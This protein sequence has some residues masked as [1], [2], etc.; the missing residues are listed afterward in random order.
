PAS[1]GG[2][3]VLASG[4]DPEDPIPRTIRLIH[5]AKS[6]PPLSVETDAT[7]DTEGSSVW[8]AATS[9]TPKRDEIERWLA[10]VRTRGDGI[11]GLGM[12]RPRG[13]PGGDVESGRRLSPRPSYR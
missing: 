3:D 2:L 7:R 10:T 9:S 6:A 12:W 5:S 4:W 8:E 13:G 1:A 11:T